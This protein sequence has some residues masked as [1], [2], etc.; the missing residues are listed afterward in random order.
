M[1]WGLLR[2]TEPASLKC[3]RVSFHAINIGNL[4]KK[5]AEPLFMPCTPKGII[6]LLKHTGMLNFYTWHL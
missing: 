6:E 3:Y 4:S 5:S 2:D 1:L